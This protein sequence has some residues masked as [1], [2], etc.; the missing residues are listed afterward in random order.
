MLKALDQQQDTLQ[1]DAQN[2]VSL[3]SQASGAVGQM[4]AIQAAN[5]LA[6]AQANQLLQ[7]RSILVAQNAATTPAQA[8]ADKDAIQGAASESLRA[9]S[10]VIHPGSHGKSIIDE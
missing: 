8:E 5:Q 4:Q 1:S 10:Y 3:Q 2:L 6:S 7:I 9:G